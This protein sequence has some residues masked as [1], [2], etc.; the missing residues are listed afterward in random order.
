[1]RLVRC[2]S[3]RELRPR[4][5]PAEPWVLRHPVGGGDRSRRWVLR[6]RPRPAG[7]RSER[8]RAAPG[9]RVLEQ[10]LLAGAI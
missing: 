6:L 10:E 4:L 8:D 3:P 9:A 5:R 7:R 1:L 2:E